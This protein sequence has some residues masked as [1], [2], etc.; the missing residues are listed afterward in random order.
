MRVW[1]SFDFLWSPRRYEV[2]KEF[3]AENPSWVEYEERLM[4][5]QESEMK[6]KSLPDFYDFGAIRIMAGENSLLT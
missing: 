6:L 5:C 4:E 2:V 1:D 3:S